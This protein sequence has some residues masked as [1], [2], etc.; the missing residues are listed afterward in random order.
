MKQNKNILIFI[1]DTSFPQGAVTEPSQN[2]T[3]G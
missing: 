2:Q 3:R 1:K